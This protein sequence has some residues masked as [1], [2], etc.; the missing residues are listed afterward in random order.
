MVLEIIMNIFLVTIP[1]LLH[2]RHILYSL[3]YREAQASYERHTSERA[4]Y[5]LGKEA[6]GELHSLIFIPAPFSQG[7]EG[8]LTSF[9]LYQKCHGIS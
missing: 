5:S 6:F 1:G 3:H 2:G 7:E 9:S 4:E 8:F